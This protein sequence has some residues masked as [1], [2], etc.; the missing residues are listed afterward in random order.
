M[1]LDNLAGGRG[2]GDH[3]GEQRRAGPPAP[4]PG[5]DGDVDDADQV[6]PML[7]VQAPRRLAF[8]ENQVVAG[9]GELRSVLQLSRP[10]LQFEERF[11]LRRAPAQ[12]IEF[13]L[14]GRGVQRPQERLV[15]GRDGAERDRIRR[16]SDDRYYPPYN[17]VMDITDDRGRALEEVTLRLNPK[18]V[19]DLLVGASS[20]DDGA[21]DHAVVRDPDSGRS[22]ALYLAEEGEPTD[23]ERQTDWW[24][25]PII[26]VVVLFVAVGAF[27]IARGLIHSLF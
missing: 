5:G 23:L 12:P 14:P 26:L 17:R 18:E 15:A 9:A 2:L 8:D 11:G 21:A 13:P 10:E 27:T 25:G 7:H 16:D 1:E 6:L 20:I 22:V 3:P 19:A 24:V 4:V